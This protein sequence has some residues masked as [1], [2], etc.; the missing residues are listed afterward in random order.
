MLPENRQLVVITNSLPAALALAARPGYT[1]IT[2][3]GRVRDV[4]LGEV[5]QFALR[6][7]Q[8]LSVDI[9]FLGSNGIS[10]QRGLTTPDAAEADVKRA[11]ITAAARRVLLADSSKIGAVALW[12]YGSVSDIDLLITDAGAAD[13]D[14]AALRSAGPRV[15]VAN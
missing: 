9:A 11:I 2:L 7:L 4:T 1:V 15:L 10:V 13:A 3:G 8:E 6:S 12:R 5:G 14:I